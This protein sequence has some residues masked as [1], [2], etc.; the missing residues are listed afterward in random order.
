MSKLQTEI[1]G[2]AGTIVGVYLMVP[3]VLKVLATHHMRDVSFETVVLYV[4][5]CF[6]WLLYGIGKKGKQIW[7]ANGIALAIGIVQLVL[8][9]RFG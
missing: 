2:W 1:A 9:M 8:K 3:Q 7:I 6:C 5:N 4:L